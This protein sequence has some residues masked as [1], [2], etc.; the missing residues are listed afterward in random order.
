MRREITLVL[1]ALSE[2][3]CPYSSKRTRPASVFF[4]LKGCMALSF[5]DILLSHDKRRKHLLISSLRC[6]QEQK[7]PS[8]LT[9]FE[10]KESF[11]S[12]RHIESLIGIAPS[13][14]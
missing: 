13:S 2:R 6:Y 10:E 14:S 3:S 12:Y 11:T 1:G 5:F 8:T 4:L 7:T 9:R